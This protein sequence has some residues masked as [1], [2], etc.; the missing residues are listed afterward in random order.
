[1][2][3]MD[4]S[5]YLMRQAFYTCVS[6]LVPV[7][8]ASSTRILDWYFSSRALKRLFCW[9]KERHIWWYIIDRT[10]SSAGLQHL[11]VRK[12]SAW[13]H[14][15]RSISCTTFRNRQATRWI[16]S[17]KTLLDM[18]WNC[19]QLVGFQHHHIHKVWLHSSSPRFHQECRWQRLTATVSEHSA[20]HTALS[21]SQRHRTNRIART[22][23][24][25][26]LSSRT[27]FGQL[28]SKL[29]DFIISEILE[30]GRSV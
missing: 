5:Q 15:R 6:S 21:P 7:A 20:T 9:Q 18:K 16:C 17:K 22:L 13:V 24:E 8:R 25:R 3:M 28:T 11:T 12:C 26:D 27:R 4:L 10:P 23:L 30:A 1:M 19:F 29:F 14:I 2:G